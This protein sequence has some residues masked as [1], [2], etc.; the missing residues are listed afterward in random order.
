MERIKFMF[1]SSKWFSWI[2]TLIS[3]LIALYIM[4]YY[5][6]PW[7]ELVISNLDDLN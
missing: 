2:V 4:K 6:I 3:F 7:F 5:Y 1:I